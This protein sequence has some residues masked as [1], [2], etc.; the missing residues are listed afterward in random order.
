MGVDRHAGAE[1]G[2]NIE[3]EIKNRIMMGATL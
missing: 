1:D 3:P 2:Y